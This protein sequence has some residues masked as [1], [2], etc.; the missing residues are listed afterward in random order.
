MVSLSSDRS[1]HDLNL[2]VTDKTWE[3]LYTTY[4]ISNNTVASHG[5][6]LRGETALIFNLKYELGTIKIIF[7]LNHIVFLVIYIFKIVFILI[8]HLLFLFYMKF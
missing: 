3:L 2:S 4:F 5:D 1:G 7:L 6:L 8:L